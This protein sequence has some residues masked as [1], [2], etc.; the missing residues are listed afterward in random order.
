MGLWG[1]H[2]VP[3]IVD[4][5]CGTK[6]AHEVRERVCAGLAGEV[7]EIGFGSGLNLPHYPPAVMR[8][9]AV[10]P[11][12]VGLRLARDRIAASPIEVQRTGLDGQA[13][14]LDDASVD[15]ALS[16]W[17]LCTIPDAVAALAEVRRVLRPGGRL[18]FAEHGLAPD[19]RVVRWQHRLE[20]V[21]RRVAGGCH[22]TRPIT[23]LLVD[24]GFTVDR[25]DNSYEKGTPKP[26]GYLYEGVASA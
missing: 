1:R 15:N 26:F 22:L 11:S 14:P 16:T 20:P 12:D 21:Q 10:E 3:R 6:Q 7:L 5:A 13:L 4:V 17:T 25:L 23:R 19:A 9:L 24:A 18:H 2:V 8:V